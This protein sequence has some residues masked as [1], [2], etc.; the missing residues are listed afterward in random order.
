MIVH[1][2]LLF[3]LRFD[4]FG[5]PVALHSGECAFSLQRWQGLD[6]V[7]GFFLTVFRHFFNA[8]LIN[9]WIVV[10]I[11]KISILNDEKV[12]RDLIGCGPKMCSE[13]TI[14]EITAGLSPACLPKEIAPLGHRFEIIVK[15]HYAHVAGRLTLVVQLGR[16]RM[17]RDLRILRYGAALAGPL[18][19][20]RNLFDPVIGCVI[21]GW[22]PLMSKSTSAFGFLRLN[23]SFD[24]VLVDD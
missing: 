14:R 5:F 22:F 21:Y 4:V 3:F 17:T 9:V 20:F 10:N 1:F 7:S 12:W 11:G 16:G 6:F 13:F 18:I 15:R 19:A 23:F 8:F 2:V 24:C